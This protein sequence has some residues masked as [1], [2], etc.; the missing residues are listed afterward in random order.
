MFHYWPQFWCNL[1][2]SIDNHWKI[3]ARKSQ[4]GTSTGFQHQTQT[5]SVNITPKINKNKH[6]NK[7][8]LFFLKKNLEAKKRRSGIWKGVTTRK[9]QNS[10]RH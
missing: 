2:N 9:S 7:E 6:Q 3:F 8:G 1:F 10:S 4:Q 5:T